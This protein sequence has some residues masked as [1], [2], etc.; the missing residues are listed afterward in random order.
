MTEYL[1]TFQDYSV[2]FYRNDGLA[3]VKGLSG[4]ENERMNTC[5]LENQCQTLNLV[6]QR[7][8]AENKVNDKKKKYFG[9]AVTTF[10]ERF[11]NH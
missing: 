1:I 9:L 8:D 11:R 10:N 4:P 7:A 6:I 3:L 5:P 2:V